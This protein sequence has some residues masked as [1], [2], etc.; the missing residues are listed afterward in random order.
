[1]SI[2]EITRYIKKRLRGGVSEEEITKILLSV[3]HEKKRIEEGFVA[4][5]KSLKRNRLGLIIGVCVV[6]LVFV[7][8]FA[9]TQVLTEPVEEAV[10]TPV[11]VY[12][13][14]V[15]TFDVRVS[16]SS[17]SP[18]V[19][20]ARVGDTVLFSLRSVDGGEYHLYVPDF[21]FDVVVVDVV[22]AAGFVVSEPGEFRMF[23]VADN[24]INIESKI[25]VT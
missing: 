19:I 16:S 9:S 20:E 25:I 4:A 3:G 8:W 22:E 10:K 2:Q 5:R 6:V 18:A 14:V 12:E 11:E 21:G 24:G 13:P 7:V 1:M 23:N 15:R 17:I